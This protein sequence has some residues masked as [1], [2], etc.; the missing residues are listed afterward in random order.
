MIYLRLTPEAA[1][2]I[3]VLAEHAG[4]HDVVHQISQQK[5]DLLLPAPIPSLAVWRAEHGPEE[6]WQEACADAMWQAMMQAWERFTR[7]TRGRGG[8]VRGEGHQP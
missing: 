8:A 3:K 6:V 1:L 5:L 2:A 4:L 7:E